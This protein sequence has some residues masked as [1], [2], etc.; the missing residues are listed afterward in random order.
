VVFTFYN[1]SL[2]EEDG[3]RVCGEDA[4]PGGRGEG[5]DRFLPAACRPYHP[6]R[7]YLRQDFIFLF[8]LQFIF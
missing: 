8:K 2:D 6:R 5:P 7:T 4:H 3:S 1:T